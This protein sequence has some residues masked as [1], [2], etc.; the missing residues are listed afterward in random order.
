MRFLVIS[1]IILKRIFHPKALLSHTHN[2]RTQKIQS[3]CVF[4]PKIQSLCVFAPK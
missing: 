3:L 4:A 1:F 2:K